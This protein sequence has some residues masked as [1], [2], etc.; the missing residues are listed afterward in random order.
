MALVPGTQWPK[1]QH[2]PAPHLRT[3]ILS[4]TRW[5][6]LGSSVKN[7]NNTDIPGLHSQGLQPSGFQAE[8]SICTLQNLPGVYL[9]SPRPS[10]GRSCSA[11]EAGGSGK[12][13]ESGAID[14]TPPVK[15]LGLKWSHF[16]HCLELGRTRFERQVQGSAALGAP[17]RTAMERTRVL[18]VPR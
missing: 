3:V 13:A 16:G 5:E 11:G 10:A 6:M 15:W 4:P 7:R 9:A 14:R 12:G 8:Q 17:F 18:G 2:S 1:V